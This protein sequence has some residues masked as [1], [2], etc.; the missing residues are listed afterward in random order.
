MS[1]VPHPYASAPELS[2]ETRAM[3]SA[4]RLQWDALTKRER[5]AL[6][7]ARKGVYLRVSLTTDR[8]AGRGLA[9]KLGLLTIAGQFVRQVGIAALVEVPRG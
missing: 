2:V 7:A 9:T 1:R 8:L 4:A 6:V 3:L 5:S